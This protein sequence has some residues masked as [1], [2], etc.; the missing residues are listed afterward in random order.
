MILSDL[1]SLQHDFPSMLFGFLTPRALYNL[2]CA[3]KLFCA[4]SEDMRKCVEA[5]VARYTRATLFFTSDGGGLRLFSKYGEHT[6]D[7]HVWPH[8]NRS[9]HNLML[10][11][12]NSRQK[13]HVF[14]GY[15]DGAMRKEDDSFHYL[16]NQFFYVPGMNSIATDSKV[17]QVWISQVT[18]IL[19]R[20]AP[21]YCRGVSLR[22]Y[23]KMQGHGLLHADHTFY[24]VDGQNNTM[25]Y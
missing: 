11:L 13:K 7:F 1:V 22:V 25:L 19:M 5:A 10:E 2:R 20:M 12:S 9:G 8:T 23:L 21:K 3:G 4:S 24:A 6:A 16:G 18:P 17:E 14:Y 15:M